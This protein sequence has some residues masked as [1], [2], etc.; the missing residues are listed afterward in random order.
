MSIEQIPLTL[1]SFADGKLAAEVDEKIAIILE[2]F[3]QGE[4]GEVELS[5]DK[6]TI[7]VK[8]TIERDPSI[9]GFRCAFE[10]P[11]LK[12]PAKVTSGTVAIERDGILIVSAEVPAEQMRLVPAKHNDPKTN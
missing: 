9:G 10:E 7:T 11:N 4:D 6:A 5:S 3:R 1:L 8:L 12:L 2:R